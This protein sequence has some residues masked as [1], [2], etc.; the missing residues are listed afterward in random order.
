MRL[1]G[2]TGAKSTYSGM[3]DVT[4]LENALFPISILRLNKG[5]ILNAQSLCGVAIEDKTIEA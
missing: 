4:D 1:S 2:C 5:K 3:S